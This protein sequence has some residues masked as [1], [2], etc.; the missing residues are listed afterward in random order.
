MNPRAAFFIDGFNLYHSLAAFAKETGDVT[1]KWLD[2]V[3]LADATLHEIGGGASL[4]SVHYFT[5]MPEH[6]YISDPGGSSGIGPICV[7]LRPT[8]AHGLPL[9]SAGSP[10]NR[11]R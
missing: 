1:V 11:C 9:S 6:L 3:G 2:V 10:S 5:A 8:E 4:R 7:R